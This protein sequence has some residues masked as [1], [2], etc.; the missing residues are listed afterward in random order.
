M[1]NIRHGLNLTKRSPID[2]TYIIAIAPTE[3]LDPGCANTFVVLLITS[4]GDSSTIK[5]K[6]LRLN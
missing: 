5:A 6:T 3:I 1:I 2:N 4:I